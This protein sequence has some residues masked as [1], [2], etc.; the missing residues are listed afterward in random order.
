[1][2]LRPRRKAIVGLMRAQSFRLRNVHASAARRNS[3]SRRLDVDLSRAG[4]RDFQTAQRLCSM[5]IRES[6]A[7]GRSTGRTAFLECW[8]VCHESDLLRVVVLALEI[9]PLADLA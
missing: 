3:T 4:A 2:K 7:D 9:T 8:H 5:G 1:M 6:R